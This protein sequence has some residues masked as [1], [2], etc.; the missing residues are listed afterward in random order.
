MKMGGVICLEA[1]MELV[2]TD[3]LELCPVHR[4]YHFNTIR[5]QKKKK[6]GPGCMEEHLMEVY[7]VC[8]E[9]VLT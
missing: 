8:N 6:Y 4:L 5:M 7:S 3:P 2:L 9:D 1:D